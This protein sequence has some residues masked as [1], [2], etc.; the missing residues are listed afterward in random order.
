MRKKSVRTR[1]GSNVDV[2]GDVGVGM[3]AADDQGYEDRYYYL[4]G[5]VMTEKVHSDPPEKVHISK[6]REKIHVRTL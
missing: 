6:N 3:P 1:I 4:W 2:G 5:I